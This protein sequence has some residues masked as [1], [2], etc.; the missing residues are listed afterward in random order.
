M[1]GLAFWGCGCGLGVLDVQKGRS[2]PTP[3]HQL[4]FTV[5]GFSI[6]GSLLDTILHFCYNKTLTM[7]KDDRFQYG[8]SREPDLRYLI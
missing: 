6:S 3:S 2:D 7:V 1:E 4:E 5:L 8:P